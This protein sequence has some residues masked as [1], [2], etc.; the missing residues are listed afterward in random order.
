VVSTRHRLSIAK[1]QGHTSIRLDE[2]F[3][4]LASF[5]RAAI[6]TALCGAPRTRLTTAVEKSDRDSSDRANGAPRA[7]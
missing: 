2:I 3:G 1:K 7:S 5:R 4:G 6:P